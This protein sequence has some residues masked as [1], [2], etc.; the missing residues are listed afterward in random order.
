VS[1]DLALAAVLL[2]V[3]SRNTEADDEEA[4]ERLRRVAMSDEIDPLDVREVYADSN[5]VR[6]A[7]GI[8]IASTRLLTKPVDCGI[9]DARFADVYRIAMEQLSREVRRLLDEV[10]K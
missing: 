2:E 7:V 4:L 8:A 1:D 6:R 3:Q 9:C 5:R 10:A